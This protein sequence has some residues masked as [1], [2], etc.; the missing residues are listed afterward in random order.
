MVQGWS[1]VRIL[2]V[3][4]KQV[5]RQTH[6]LAKAQEV[7]AMNR[8]TAKLKPTGDAHRDRLVAAKL[9]TRGIDG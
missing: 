4:M 3:Q 2:E 9:Q 7:A 5:N 8:R 6:K 1:G